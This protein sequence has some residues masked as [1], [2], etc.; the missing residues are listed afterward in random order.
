MK[1]FALI[2]ILLLLLSCSEEPI[3]DNPYDPGFDLPEPE[4]SSLDDI[5]LTCKLLS[6]DYELD[7]IEGFMINRRDDTVWQEEIMV[8]PDERTWLDTAAAVNKHIQYKIKAVAGENE[9]DY[10]NSVILDNIIP[11]PTDFNV[12]QENV[13]CYNLSWEQDYIVGE[14]GFILERKIEE[15]EYIQI[16]V[17]SENIESYHDEWEYSRDEN[18]VYYR[19]KTYVGEEYS[20]TVFTNN[21]ILNAP[22]NLNYE[23]IAINRLAI[24][25]EDNTDGEQGFKID[26]KVGDNEWSENYAITSEDIVYW[27]DENS[28]INQNF[29]YRVYAYY[30]GMESASIQSDIIDNNIPAPKNLSLEI[31]NENEI[32]LTWEYDLEGITGF[33]IE[34]K[35]E[36]G[37][38][39]LYTENIAP[40]IREWTDDEC[41][42]LDR[43]RI[44]A[45]FQEYES[46]YSN[47]V[48][49]GMENMNYVE[50]GSF[51]MGDHYNEGYSD[52]LPVHEVTLS[53]FFIGQYEVKQGEYEELMGSNPAHDYGV[54]DNYPVYFI[55]WYDAIEYC[56]ALSEQEDLTPCYNLDDWS[57]DF[58]ANGFR[59]PTEAEWEYTARGGV[60]WMD[61]YR[62]SGTTD[63]LGDYAWYSSNSE[64]QTHE[65]GTKEAN[66]LGI[67]DM[68]GNVY[69]W[70]NDW[71]SVSY[72][73]SSTSVN[74]YG[75]V[76][77]SSQVIRGGCWYY[78]ISYCRIADRNYYYPSD[79]Y[80]GLGFRIACS[81]N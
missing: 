45:Y 5:S 17:L 81:S 15:G 23:I 29:Q 24:Y 57:C 39:E 4:I 18:I 6:W 19:I 70:C 35:A 79:S 8:S 30:E 36:E 16:A 38:W 32:R 9:S 51:E 7:N 76:T 54:G 31:I 10:V 2:S 53:S 34:K 12:V 66:Q 25:W 22:S 52:E 50:G 72:Y 69:E 47:V 62:Y 61:N 26:K 67:Y 28:E 59:L 68:S 56:N 75:P 40:E 44:K 46:V 80:R 20:G 74:P 3:R 60:N 43:Y 64:S 65:V 37:T 41:V 55:T 21:Q 49:W 13:H 48:F 1:Y 73:N 42:H 33:G 71:Y 14:D 77:G 11:V 78:S 27:A 58:N 63:N